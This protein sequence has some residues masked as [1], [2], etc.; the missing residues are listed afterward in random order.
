MFRERDAEV[1]AR[2]EMLESRD[3]DDSSLILDDVSIGFDTAGVARPIG[4]AGV[5]LRPIEP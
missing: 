2:E 1:K 4:Q 3:T 5:Y